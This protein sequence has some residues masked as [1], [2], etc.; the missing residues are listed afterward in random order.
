MQPQGARVLVARGSGP[1]AWYPTVRAMKLSSIFV[2]KASRWH[3]DYLCLH[4]RPDR[5]TDNDRPPPTEYLCVRVTDEH[6]NWDKIKSVILDYEWY[7]SYGEYGTSGSNPHL[8]PGFPGYVTQIALESDLKQLVILT[9]VSCHRCPRI[10]TP[11]SHFLGNVRLLAT[12]DFVWRAWWDFETPA[13]VFAYPAVPPWV[14]PCPV[15]EKP[16]AVRNSY[17]K[18][19]VHR[20]PRTQIPPPQRARPLSVH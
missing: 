5:P 12:G 19:L 11:S 13:F 7:I 9:I 20:T 1:E 16:P 3:G 2:Y 8:L 17:Y 10:G 15:G 6:T 4:D 14:P 18:M